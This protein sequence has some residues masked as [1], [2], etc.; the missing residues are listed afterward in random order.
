ML[1][2]W[3]RFVAG[4]YPPLPSVAFAFLWAYGVSGLFA[5]VQPAHPAWRPGLGTLT[6][7]LTLTVTLL[8]MRAVDDI[9]DLAYDRVFNPR[10]P[11][12]SDAVRERDLLVLCAAGA[13]LVLALNAGRPAALAVLA[14]QLGYCA[15]VLAADRALGWP[16]GDR[17]LLSLLISFP[18]QLLL[19]VYL[20]TRYLSDTGQG[21]GRGGVLAIAITVLVTVHLEFAKKITRR[22]RPGERSYVSTLG[23]GGTVAVALA[24]PVL[25]VLLLVTQARPEALLVPLALLPLLLPARAGWRF[26]RAHAPRWPAASAAYYVLSTFACYLALSLAYG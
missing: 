24:A 22:L 9:R 11:L 1:S 17:L 14:G 2:R 19:H 26:F 12:A 20:Y 8:L 16:P 13:V 25:A 5:V 7:A 3:A 15:L 18:A 21:A 23:L 10:R 6:A 4:S